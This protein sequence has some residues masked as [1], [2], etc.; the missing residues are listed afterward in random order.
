MAFYYPETW[1]NASD[2]Y[3]TDLR[4]QA[5]TSTTFERYGFRPRTPTAVFQ[6]DYTQAWYFTGT[7][8]AELLHGDDFTVTGTWTDPN[9]R[10]TLPNGDIDLEF[11][12]NGE[13]VEVPWV[14][15]LCSWFYNTTNPPGSQGIRFVTYDINDTVLTTYVHDDLP[16]RYVPG[17]R[18]SVPFRVIEERCSR[19]RMTHALR[20]TNTS[21]GSRNP[22]GMGLNAVVLPD[23]YANSLRQTRSARWSPRRNTH[24]Q[25]LKRQ[26]QI[27]P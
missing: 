9:A 16:Y 22:F 25:A 2:G 21:Q 14:G 15:L 17:D 4:R 10:K 12:Q 27:A 7:N 20:P 24:R 6:S 13:R 3:S 23:F 19:V 11:V 5:V 8:S 1:D 26:R 18:G